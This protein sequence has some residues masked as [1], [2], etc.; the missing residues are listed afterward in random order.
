M[1]LFF[2]EEKVRAQEI[3]LKTGRSARAVSLFSLLLKIVFFASFVFFI[4]LLIDFGEIAVL[5]PSIY[6]RA[7]LFALFLAGAI[8]AVLFY[9]VS[10]FL[11]ARW[12]YKNAASLQSFRTYFK[13]LSLR[14]IGKAIYLFLFSRVLSILQFVFYLSPFWI[15]S[16]L[17]LQKWKRSGFLPLVFYVYL[18]FLAVLLLLGLYFFLV[19]LQKFE[20]FFSL[21]TSHPKMPLLEIISR[22]KALAKPLVF[23]LLRGKLQFM[24]WG[25][26][27]LLL[28]PFFYVSPYYA[29]TLGCVQKSV[30]EQHHLAIE[31]PK[32][33]IFMRPSPIKAS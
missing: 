21:L 12:F 28:L 29:Q 5:F 22:G 24:L 1:T 6:A 9:A 31:P 30:L 10:S 13:K 19:S 18:G 7:A 23:P 4:L 32:P 14:E 26:F 25:I 17:F 8:C 15:A 3:L 2:K 27:T 11:R 33:V 20:F 16:V